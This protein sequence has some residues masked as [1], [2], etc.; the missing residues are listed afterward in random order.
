MPTPS[1]HPLHRLWRLLPTEARRSLLA[2]GTALLAPRPVQPAPAARHGLIVAGELTRASG[3]GEGARL[4]LAGLQELGIAGWPMRA[5]LR[6]P[7]E[8][9]DI[10]LAPADEP[11]SG[12]PLVLHVNAPH[13][14]AALLRL[15]RGLVRGR[16]VIGCWAWEL[17]QYESPS[18]QPVF[19]NRRMSLNG[20]F[21]SNTR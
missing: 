14:A 4:M 8:A 21:D 6:L 3:L 17:Q 2:R 9:D 5:G 10:A 7:G 19:S 13:V 1:L 12:A 20:R 11:P 18:P 16:R 15:P